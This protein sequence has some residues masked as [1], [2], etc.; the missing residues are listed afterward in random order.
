MWFDLH[1]EQ[2]QAQLIYADRSQNRGHHWEFLDGEGAQ[3]GFWGNGMSAG[4]MCVQ[5]VKI[6]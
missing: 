5:Y 2:K 6:H 4:Y 1:K 3:E